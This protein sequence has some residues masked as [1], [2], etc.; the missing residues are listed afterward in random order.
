MKLSCALIFSCLVESG[1][2]FAHRDRILPIGFDGLMADVPPQFGTAN[3]KVTF[4]GPMSTSTSITSMVLTLGEKR[5]EVPACITNVL[6][7]R[8]M[9]EV[10]ATGSWYHDESTMPYYLNLSFFDPGYS[11]RRWANPGIQLLFNLRTG[12]LI[13]V[14]S[15][16]VGDNDR[17]L[18]HVAID[19]KSRC[20]PEV[21]AGL[22]SGPMQ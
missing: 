4:S 13:E 8:K 20:S 3:L 12:K 19:L 2:A 16:V 18:R 1:N 11:A 9:S 15:L 5:I 10:E 22:K 6:R 17:S 21:L 7:S 14:E